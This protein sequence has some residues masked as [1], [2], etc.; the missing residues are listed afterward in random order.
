[1]LLVAHVSDTHF[2]GGPRAAERATRVVDYLNS[3]IRPAD[4]VVVSGD[5]TDHGLDAEYAQVRTV[6]DQ[7]RTPVYFLPGNHDQRGPFRAFLAGVDADGPTGGPGVDGDAP[8]NQLIQLD[9]ATFALC[10]STIPG[11][12]DGYLSEETLGWLAEVAEATDPATALFVCFHHP[13]VNLHSG[14]LDPIRQHGEDRLAAVLDGRRGR[15][16]LLCGHAHTP[17]ATTF[18]GVPLIVGPSVAS[19]LVLPWEPSPDTLDFDRPPALAMHVLDDTG[20]LTTH[21]RTLS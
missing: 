8:I 4:A 1:M 14:L 15:T 3:L 6:F 16:V 11:R 9:R 21:Y 17:A 12:L 13:P 10:D 18:A 7:L 5:V 19:T 20:T 2:D